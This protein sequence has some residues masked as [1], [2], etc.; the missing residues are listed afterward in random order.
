MILQGTTIDEKPTNCRELLASTPV[1]ETRKTFL[2][3][4]RHMYPRWNISK[5]MKCVLAQKTCSMR[6]TFN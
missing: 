5:I 1:T 2:K 3:R 6:V 4:M